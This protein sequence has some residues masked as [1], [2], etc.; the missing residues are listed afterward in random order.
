[1]SVYTQHGEL[2]RGLRAL[3]LAV[4]LL[5][6]SVS[7][8]APAVWAQTITVTTLDDV[9]DT[10]FTVEND[11]CPATGAI[12]DLPG[13]DG[14]V[15]LREAMIA[16][17][18]T[19]GA[20]TIVFDPSLSG[21]SVL[22]GSPL[23]ALCQNSTTINGDI[24]ANEQA[25][26]I[27]IESEHGGFVILGSDNR[28][29]AL[30][31]ANSFFGIQVIGVRRGTERT[32]LTN[33]SIYGGAFGI[34]IGGLSSYSRLE[35]TV[36]DR[37]DVA[38][39]F[40][41]I[42]VFG[43]SR[44]GKIIGTQITNNHV[45]ESALG[46]G[47]LSQ[48]DYTRISDFSIRGNE[49]WNTNLGIWVIG[50]IGDVRQGRLDAY[51]G[52]NS[53]HHN[54]AGGEGLGWGI[55]VSGGSAG[56]SLC[57]A[58]VQVI[59]NLVVDN[60]SHGVMVFGGDNAQSSRNK[61][62]VSGNTI[63][64]NGGDGLFIAGGIGSFLGGGGAV[65]RKNTLELTVVNNTIA[66]Q[67][68]NGVSLWGGLGSED[69]S[70]GTAN[71]NK[72]NVTEFSGNQ[73][74]NSGG[75]GILLAGGGP[76]QANKNVIRGT[77]SSRVTIAESTSCGNVKGDIQFFGLFPGDAD[78]PAGTGGQNIVRGFVTATQADTIAASDGV[79]GNTGVVETSAITA[80]P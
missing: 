12:A 52:Q 67:L 76:S 6:V 22:V 26:D 79:A 57:R 36:I 33:N 9:A 68:G 11:G 34:A 1:M 35:G 64:G 30:R 77:S 70:E 3:C 45:H 25:D 50:C 63:T 61:V 72:V 14:E 73:I 16:A 46:I 56:A 51:I 78:L 7:W 10:P 2:L 23:P 41:G 17:D 71:D 15:S 53:V 75:Y 31:I 42:V 37:N 48:D 55:L 39:E 8:G 44:R 38:V 18:V 54:L 43:S 80:C 65:T 47:L 58:E 60:D 74:S 4:G 69:G 21:G 19:P 5:A 49:V 40:Y 32:V 24:N 13:D 62:V 27:T 20:Q 59:E 29:H 66:N 28:I